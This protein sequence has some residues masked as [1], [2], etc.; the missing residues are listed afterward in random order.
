M[1]SQVSLG[2]LALA[3]AAS[4]PAFALA[5]DNASPAVDASAA[6][7]AQVSEVIVTGT[8][9]STRTVLT[10]PA[11]IDV[12]STAAIEASGKASTRDVIST[13]VPSA[14]T[15]NS[16]AGASFAVKTLSLRGLS[17]DES[18]VL[19]DGKR[20]HDTAILFV[21]GTTQNGQ[22]PA[23]LDLIPAA[24]IERIE[25][26]RDGASAQYGSDALA[27]V[28]NI[29]TRKAPQGGTVSALYGATGA[30]DGQTE[31]VSGNIGFALLGRGYL[32][33]SAIAYTRE[34]AD[35]GSIT[36]NATVMYYPLNALNQPVPVGTP[37]ATP[38]PREATA[39]RHTSHPGVPAEQL[40]AAS[41]SAGLP[42]DNGVELYAEGTLSSRNNTAWLT[43][44]NPDSIN[45]NIAVYPD[46][47]SPKLFLK[48]RDF[49]LT[50][51]AKGND[52]L[53]FHWD[54]STTFGQDVVDYSENSLN[55]SLGPASPSHFYL[56]KLTAK[57]WT[58]NLDL[59]RELKTGLFEQP[60]FLAAGLE[61]RNNQFSIGAGDAPSYVNGGYSAPL[62]DPLF[63]KVLA[64]GSQGVTGFPP[65][66]AGT[67]SRDNI[68]VYVDAEQKLTSRLQVSGAVRYEHYS[69]FGSA[70]TGKI[71]SR[72]QLLQGL[73]LRGTVS[74]GFRAPSLQQE[75]YASSSTIGVVVPPAKVAQLYPVQLLPPDNPAA[76][77]L[78]AKP[79]K[80]ETSDSAS[81]GLVAQP[82]P[83]LSLTIDAYEIKIH[84]R[85]LQSSTLGP[86]AAVSAALASQGLNPQQ[87]VFYYGNFAN[88][89]NKGVDIVAEYRTDLDTLG[90]VKWQAS[91]TFSDA[92][93]DHIVQPT[94]AGIP[95][96]LGRDRIGDFTV[97][98]PRNKEILG[99]NWLNGPFEANLRV[100]RYGHLVQ[101]STVAALDSA[102][103]PKI[104]TD[105]ELTYHLNKSVSLI[106]GGDNLLD[107]YPTPIK[108]GLRGTPAFAYYNQY[109][110]YGITGGYYYT[111]VSAK[112]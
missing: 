102:L 61:Y 9:S 105:L 73:A 90:V 67:F 40:Y 88:T 11:P 37:G 108:P 70:T 20:R 18:L 35:R 62:G 13:L 2:A 58:T 74:T 98:T 56:G 29:I 31:Q 16:G 64:G 104:I 96:Y 86:S 75:H 47:Y 3:L 109:A 78:G 103:P 91:A 110:P 65:F 93:F 49:Q 100:T 15:S 46:G 6:S 55:A 82:L 57:E 26:L 99:A 81:F 48:D 5:A 8:R 10:S 106:V 54:L 44:R 68:G 83:R 43:F 60:L 87:A 112:F 24:G 12:L 59:N 28:I 32:D 53:S 30:G 101:R 111:R 22:S 107:V 33:L 71:S 42:L 80:A 94:V 19:V 45:N 72:Y 92:K 7:S 69:D 21:N 41:F 52:F 89:T 17:S 1:K 34:I 79:L 25:V 84:D 85:I 76:G 39:D 97:G 77:A 14:N 27:G 66:A 38:D 4:H 50:A 51:G 95:A 63:G 36:P 23:D